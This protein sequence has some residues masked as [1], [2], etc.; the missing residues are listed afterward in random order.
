MD[1]CSV[2]AVGQY[3]AQSL[4][5][6]VKMVLEEQHP[7]TRE[8]AAWTLSRV[9]EYQYAAVP[10]GSMEHIVRAALTGLSDQQGGV[11]HQCCTM[12]HR[13]A[14]NQNDSDNEN[15]NTNL[16]SQYFNTVLQE[17]TKTSGRQAHQEHNLRMASH[18]ALNLW[19][20]NS[21]VDCLQTITALLPPILQRLQSTLSMPLSEQTELHPRLLS[22]VNVCLN[23]LYSSDTN[24]RPN[25][26]LNF[27]DQVMQSALTI[28]ASNN[29]APVAEAECLLVIM[30]V[31]TATDEDFFKYIAAAYPYIKK[32]IEKTDAI[33]VSKCGISI[34]GDATQ[35][36]GQKMLPYCDDIMESFVKILRNHLVEKQIKL[37]VFT[38]FGSIALSIGASFE[39]YLPV[40]M[41]L[42]REAA[43]VQ[44]PE[45][46]DEET[47]EYMTDLRS[48][49]MSSYTCILQGMNDSQRQ[50][51]L[52]PY[53]QSIFD[54]IQ[55]VVNVEINEEEVMNHT[56]GLIGDLA[57]VFGSHIAPLINQYQ[58][59][60]QQCLNKCQQGDGQELAQF[61][62]QKIQS[63]VSGGN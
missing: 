58:A 37:T 53:I 13:I 34:I 24:K 30:A 39:K 33:N 57:D 44:L 18:E 63:A 4:P 50:S 48:E 41:T 54:V 5:T 3:A 52:V 9:C 14:L 25:L 40:V 16:L 42:M 61:A 23:R 11:C 28:L 62:Q 22:T 15:A 51:N 8:T 49:I 6:L 27:C 43:T 29:D 19:I 46:A 17:L 60:I 26:A 7:K 38:S 35:A 59:P 45:N 31:I 2:Q 55:T 47:L 10:P 12:L 32:A 1:G 56:V 36:L 21:A 20:E